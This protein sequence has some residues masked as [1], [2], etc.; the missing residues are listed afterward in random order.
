MRLL[1]I[2]RGGQAAK[3]RVAAKP[4]SIDEAESSAASR[5]EPHETEVASVAI[6]LACA[7]SKRFS[8]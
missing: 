2:R 5:Q 6:S 4:S 8:D 3:P 7:A 1:P